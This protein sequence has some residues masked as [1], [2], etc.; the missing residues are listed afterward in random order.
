MK[1]KIITKALSTPLF[2]FLFEYSNQVMSKAMS[3][4]FPRLIYW[5]IL[6]LEVC[7]LSSI[8]TLSP[9]HL[10]TRTELSIK[11]YDRYFFS[12]TKNKRILPYGVDVIH[13]RFS[14]FS[15]VVL[16]SCRSVISNFYYRW[17]SM[18]DLEKPRLSYTDFLSVIIGDSDPLFPL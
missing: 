10:T 6:I 16:R 9:M 5:N 14:F 1:K 8:T 11:V 2:R 13:Q 17:R 12:L 4:L 18:I 7:L 3:S 15:F